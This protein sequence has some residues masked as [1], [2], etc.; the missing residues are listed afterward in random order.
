M[1]CSSISLCSSFPGS[2]K[3]AA[4]SEIKIGIVLEKLRKTDTYYAK[5]INLPLITCLIVFKEPPLRLII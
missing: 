2:P 5:L 4:Y 3:L 1:C